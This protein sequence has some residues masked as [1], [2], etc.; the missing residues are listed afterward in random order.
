MNHN[1]DL[2]DPHESIGVLAMTSLVLL[3]A[4]ATGAGQDKKSDTKSVPKVIVVLPL[5]AM[6]VRRMFIDWSP[7][8][9]KKTPGDDYDPKATLEPRCSASSG[10]GGG[11]CGGRS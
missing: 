11:Q 7:G 9:F 10:E 4:H 3:T 2:F 8:Q 6:P 5:A 1:L